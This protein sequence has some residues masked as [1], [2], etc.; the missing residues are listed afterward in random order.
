MPFR[1]RADLRPDR[2]GALLLPFAT[3]KRSVEDF[4]RGNP[5]F[6]QASGTWYAMVKRDDT[7]F[8]RR[9]RVSPAG[10]EIHVHESQIDDVM[11]SGNRV[12]TY[13]H[14]TARGALIELPLAW[15]SENGGTWAMNPGHDR[16]Y[17]LPPRTI[18]YEC[19]F[20]HNAYPR[21]PAG[22]DEPGSEP[23]YSGALPEG[24][25]CQRCHGPG[26]NH[27]RTAQ[28]A[29]SSVADIRKGDREPGPP[30][31]R[32]P[33]G[34]VHAMPSGNHQPAAAALH[35]DATTSVRFP[36]GP[37]SRWAISPSSSITPR[38]ANTRTISRSH[39]PPTACAN[40]SASFAPTES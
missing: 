31:R 24:I 9:W 27:V 12:R 21:I 17:M 22:H 29:G 13:L 39:T 5:F 11:G 3:P 28:T 23:V 16:D 15:Y 25:D 20:C 26:G 8:Q 30:D 37:A 33:D 18:A 34:G 1:N 19:M 32:A 10:Q 2:D 14:R 4:T 35:R 38:A 6:H 40:R 36:T 7:Y